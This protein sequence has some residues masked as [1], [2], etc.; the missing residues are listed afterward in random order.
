MT[1]RRAVLS[2]D[3]QVPCAGVEPGAPLSGQYRTEVSPT[4]ADRFLAVGLF[5]VLVPALY[6]GVSVSAGESSG[7][8]LVPSS[9]L[10]RRVQ[11]TDEL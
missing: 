1:S 5:H 2:A 3:G 7:A 11:S 6:R 10:V 4:R 9:G 8:C